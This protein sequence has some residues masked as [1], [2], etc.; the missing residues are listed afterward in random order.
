MYVYVCASVR[1]YSRYKH[2]L[3][4]ILLYFVFMG[5]KGVMTHLRSEKNPLYRPLSHTLE[6]AVPCWGV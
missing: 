1:L 5:S 4:H 6:I 3:L 2:D